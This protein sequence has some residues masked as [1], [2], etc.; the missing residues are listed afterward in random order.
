MQLEASVIEATGSQDP[1]V[2]LFTTDPA[3]LPLRRALEARGLRAIRVT[4]V[5]EG[6]QILDAQGPGCV[7]VVDT[8]QPAP[9]AMDAVHA[10]LQDRSAVPTLFLLP[11][12]G[13][14]A[15]ARRQKGALG[16]DDYAY[17][18]AS[19]EELVL[20]VQVLLV[21]AGL[22]VPPVEQAPRQGQ[23]I[24]LFGL[25]G[26]VGRSTIAANLAVGL[27]Q[28]YGQRVA[29]LDTDLWYSAQ[30]ALLDLDS[31]KS[32]AAL[33]HMGDH[34][35]EY[36]LTDVLVPHHSGVQVLLAPTDLS[37]VETIPPELPARLA[38]AY[39]AMFDYVIVDTHPSMEEYVL[40]LLE[41]ADRILLVTTPELGPIRATAEVLRLAPRLGWSERLM[42]VLN[43]AGSG[44]H[45]A[46]LEA[47]LDRPIDATIVS[48]GP[49]VLEAANQG[50]PVL[51]LDAARREPI[52]RDLSRLVAQ[53]VGEP[54]PT[55]EEASE[56]L[57]WPRWL[58]WWTTRLGRRGA[59]APVP[60][61]AH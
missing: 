51:L 43:R 38:T 42:L 7:A 19:V 50:Q 30:R 36:A 27:A 6:R 17:L 31:D 26:G 20:R 46:H 8:W 18:P 60:E 58:R 23:M 14:Q 34:L 53:I 28:Q 52:G 40:Q 39:R 32:I 9:Y 57:A 41:V 56:A 47:V 44:V 12:Q 45:V 37:V 11:K 21:R 15:A 61:L 10:L 49:R 35:D 59:T 5:D 54:A 16:V 24:V 13:Q 33:R 48:A 1:V 55:W 29:L 3:L 25:K 4:S 2:L 22:R